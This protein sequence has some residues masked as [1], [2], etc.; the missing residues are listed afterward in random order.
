MVQIYRWKVRNEHAFITIEDVFTSLS[1]YN[2]VDWRERETKNLVSFRY[3]SAGEQ[4][5]GCNRLMRF[6]L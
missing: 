3:K 2:L 1:S 5:K 4:E 6:N